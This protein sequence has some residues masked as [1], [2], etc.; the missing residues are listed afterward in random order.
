MCLY[1][2]FV[3]REMAVEE[4]AVGEGLAGLEIRYL[5]CLFRS[6]FHGRRQGEEDRLI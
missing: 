4:E 1:T 5:A 3:T 2:D 6:R